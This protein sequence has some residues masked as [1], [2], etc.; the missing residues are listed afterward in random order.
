MDPTGAGTTGAGR[1]RAV[2]GGRGYSFPSCSGVESC[3]SY[4]GSWRASSPEAAQTTAWR[5]P[6]TRRR[7]SSGNASP[8]ARSPPKSTRSLLRFSAEGRPEEP[9]ERIPPGNPKN[10]GVE[11][12]VLIDATTLLMQRSKGHVRNIRTALLGG[13]NSLLGRA[14]TGRPGRGDSAPAF[15]PRRD[16]R[17]EIR[18]NPEGFEEIEKTARGMARIE[19]RK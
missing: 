12:T 11:R 17:R 4:P 10:R 2:P 16:H 15:R 3:P 6:G 18:A 9:T 7:R 13:H 8:G 5:H 19:E 14:A 1:A